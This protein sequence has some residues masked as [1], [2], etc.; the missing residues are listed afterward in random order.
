MW[1][2]CH[3]DLWKLHQFPANP[4]GWPYLQ[5]STTSQWGVHHRILERW[6]ASTAQ[7]FFVRLAKTSDLWNL[8]KPRTRLA[9]AWREVWK[10]PLGIFKKP[11]GK[12]FDNQ[13]GSV[14]LAWNHL[15]GSLDHGCSCAWNWLGTRLTIQ[16]VLLHW[17]K[18]MRFDS[19]EI[20]SCNSCSA[21]VDTKEGK[22]DSSTH[23]TG[24]LP[25]WKPIS[26][27]AAMPRGVQ[28]TSSQQRG[29]EKQQALQFESNQV[30]DGV[31]W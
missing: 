16:F 5:G 20:Y 31:K 22:N 23:H 1:N 15:P 7:N 12:A 17:T 6:G 24:P 14:G 11:S 26:A 25:C 21:H 4:S 10:A 2:T 28:S 29:W 30:M 19:N 9:T 8:M 13:N 18:A 27:E 3:H